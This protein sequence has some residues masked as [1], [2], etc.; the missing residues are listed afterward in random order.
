MIKVQHFISHFHINLTMNDKTILLVEDNED[1]V[2]LTLL[3][4][5]K[6][7]FTN[8]FVVLRDGAEAIDYL[9]GNVQKQIQPSG[10]K[11]A[12]ILLDL[13]LPKINGIE[14]LRHLRS[15]EISKLIPVVVLST[16]KDRKD[17]LLSYKN[18]ANSYIIKPVDFSDFLET[19]KFLG[20][21]WLNLNEL[22]N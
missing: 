6:N 20:R 5:K 4:F 2:E 19:V 17:I 21:Y 22:P 16:S 11:P 7:N 3:A 13:N 15:N 14:V 10:L 9:L 12:L 18:G 8:S 1:D